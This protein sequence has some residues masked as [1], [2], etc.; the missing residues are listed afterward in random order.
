[1]SRHKTQKEMILPYK[2]KKDYAWSSKT[3]TKA[4]KSKT[5]TTTKKKT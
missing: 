1:M 2:Y 4:N 5:T 3:S